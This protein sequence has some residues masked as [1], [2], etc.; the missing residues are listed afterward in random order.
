MLDHVAA[1]KSQAVLRGLLTLWG[2]FAASL[3]QV[4][5]IDKLNRGK[6]R[7]SDYLEL[8]RN[9][10]QQVVEGARWIARASSS[11]DERW[12]ELRSRFMQ[13][14]ITEHRDFKMIEQ[15]YVSVG[16][17]LEEIISAPKN[18][19]TEALH[20]F[21]FHRA[22][23]PNP[24]DLLGAMFIIEGLG[25]KKASEWGAKIRDQL[26]LKSEQVSFLLYHG[27]NDEAHMQEFEDTLTSGI[28][29][30]PDMDQAILKTA[31][32]VARLYRLQLEE[33]GNA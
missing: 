10:R 24:F 22:S 30:I 11:I 28:L 13:H 31:K 1:D 8:L 9:H 7:L 16:G 5:I 33:L 27:E 25:Q 29:A 3:D 15:D 6:F 18:I 2:E 23:Q 17:K 26:G 4:P 21:I 20:A 14:A 12:F 32:V 19:G